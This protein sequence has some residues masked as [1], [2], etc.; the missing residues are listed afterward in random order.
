VKPIAQ[1]TRRI[2]FHVR[3][4]VELELQ[5]IEKQDIIEKVTDTEHTDCVSPIVV[6]PEKDGRIRL[7][8]DMR[9]ANTAIKRICHPIPTVKDISMELNGAKFFSKLDMSQ[10]YHQLELSPENR[11]VTTFTT[12]AGFYR[13]KRLNYGTNSVA[14]IFQHTLTQVLKGNKG[15]KKYG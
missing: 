10:A 5:W 1:Q 8:V 6:L 13:Y 7:C 3:D 11:S 14:E 4:K 12:H 2:P 15:V 9:A